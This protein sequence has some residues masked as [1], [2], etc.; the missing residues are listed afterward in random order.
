MRKRGLIHVVDDEEA[1]RK[2]LETM[3]SDAG[4]EV[5]SYSDARDFVENAS[6]RRAGCVVSDVRMPDMNGLQLLRWLR[7]QGNTLPVVFITGYADVALAVAAIKAGAADFLEKPF[8]AEDLL[9]AISAAMTATEV[10]TFDTEQIAHLARSQL[11]CFTPREN[12]ILEKLVSGKSNKETARELGLS[13][14]TVEFHRAHILA[15]AGVRRLP[16][17]VRLWVSA[18]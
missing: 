9:A 15:K 10:S 1:M 18:R 2:S 7:A 8:M 16:Q 11:A 3:L 6:I 5:R 4:Y 12:Q 14:R 13:P 17:L